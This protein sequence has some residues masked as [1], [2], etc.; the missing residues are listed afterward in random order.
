MKDEVPTRPRKR[1]KDAGISTSPLQKH[2]LTE[3]ENATTWTKIQVSPDRAGKTTW[4]IRH[5]PCGTVL[6]VLP[7]SFAGNGFKRCPGCNLRIPYRRIEQATQK[8][9]RRELNGE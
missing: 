6:E 3:E 1:R 5:S 8:S 4:R 2:P 9:E 7:W